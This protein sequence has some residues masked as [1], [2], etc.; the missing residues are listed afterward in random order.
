LLVRHSRLAVLTAFGGN[1]PPGA[2][3]REGQPFALNNDLRFDGPLSF[4][5]IQTLQDEEPA[6]PLLDAVMLA[7]LPLK[8][9][10]SEGQLVPVPGPLGQAVPGDAPVLLRNPR[11]AASPDAIVSRFQD[12]RIEADDLPPGTRG[13]WVSGG[14]LHPVYYLYAMES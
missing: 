9:Y 11:F 6:Y 5:I 3:F 2:A 12:W 4:Q 1:L 14:H 8:A 13:F 10:D 7:R